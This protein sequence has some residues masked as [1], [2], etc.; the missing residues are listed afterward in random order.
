[1][2]ARRSE[3]PKNEGTELEENLDDGDSEL[4]NSGARPLRSRPWTGDR[5]PGREA[6]FQAKGVERALG[7]GGTPH[8]KRCT[9][10]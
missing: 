8:R 3:G 4:R 9:R 10:V 1:V 2:K 7:S 6:A 5:G